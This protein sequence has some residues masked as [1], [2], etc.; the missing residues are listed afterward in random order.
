MLIITV[1]FFRVILLL[2]SFLPSTDDVPVILVR[3]HHVQEV[4]QTTSITTWFFHSNVVLQINVFFHEATHGLLRCR[5]NSAAFSQIQN[6]LLE[7]SSSV[8]RRATVCPDDVRGSCSGSGGSD[9]DFKLFGGS[10]CSSS[11]SSSSSSDGETKS[12]WEGGE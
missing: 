6:K 4:N 5:Q 9:F 3:L 2:V 10:G 11:S 1:I 7:L 8:K 12:I